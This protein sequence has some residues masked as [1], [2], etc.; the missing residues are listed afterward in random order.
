[1]KSP[2]P[3]SLTSLQK[4]LLITLYGK[5]LESQFP[6]SIL[7]DRYAFQAV[8]QIEYDFST[9]GLSHNALIALAVRAKQLDDWTREFLSQHANGQVVHLGCGLDCRRQRIGHVDD[10]S[11]WELDFPEVIK[12]RQH[13][14]GEPSTCQSIGASILDRKWLTDVRSDRPTLIVAEGVL[15]YFTA[16]NAK[17]LL[18]DLVTHFD[19]GQIAFDAYNW[20]GVA[21]LN[22]LPIMRQTKETLRWA[23]NDPEQLETQVPGLRLIVENTD[24]LQQHTSKASWLMRTAFERTRRIAPFRRMGQLLLF[25]FGGS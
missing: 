21:W 20:L 5:S 13:V 12:L 10:S 6:D 1:M 7:E 22:R 19:T 17:Q 14:L 4:T 9:F 3:S 24:G 15:P 23:V 11:W 8:Q 25:G 18:G 2:L 16:E